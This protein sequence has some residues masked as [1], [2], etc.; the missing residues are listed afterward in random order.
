MREVRITQL[1]G[2]VFYAVAEVE[3]PQ[4]RVAV[5]ARPSDALNLAA[6]TGAPILVE[7]AVFEASDAF[8]AA[9]TS[10]VR[11]PFG[12]GTAGAHEIASQIVARW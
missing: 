3:G 12:T 6:A 1:T 2:N 8:H 10:P 5:D 4:G 9:P 7:S 11:D